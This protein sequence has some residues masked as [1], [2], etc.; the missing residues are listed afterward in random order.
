M[1]DKL[2][3]PFVS[4]ITLIFQIIIDAWNAKLK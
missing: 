3:F 2:D 4:H 1:Y